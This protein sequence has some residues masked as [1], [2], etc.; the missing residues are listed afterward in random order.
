MIG[1]TRRHENTHFYPTVQRRRTAPDP[2]GI[3]F[4]GCLCDAPLPDLEGIGAWGTCPAHRPPTRLRRPDRTQR[5]PRVQRLWTDRPA[6]RL[7]APL[8][9]RKSTRLN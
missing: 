6:G 7:F 4:V 3:A 9:D 1:Y 8:S 5:D 2:G